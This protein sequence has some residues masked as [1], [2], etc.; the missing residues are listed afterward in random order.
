M[1][2]YLILLGVIFGIP[3]QSVMIKQEQRRVSGKSDL[4]FSGFTALF[5][6][7]LFL[8]IN[9]GAFRFSMEFLPYSIGF[10]V[11]YA[12]AF[13]CNVL[14]LSCGPMSLTLLLQSYSLLLPT[15]YGVLFLNEGV[16]ITFW[17]G[18]ALLALCLFLTYFDRSGMGE[19]IT[20]KWLILAL[21]AFL[22]NG[23]CSTVQKM[24][25]VALGGEYQNEFMILALAVIALGTLACGLWRERNVLPAFLRRGWYFGALCGLFNGGS[26]FGVMLLSHQ[27]PASLQYPLIS[28]G[29][30]LVTALFSVLLYRERLTL[31]QW[32]GFG[33]GIL[34]VVCLNL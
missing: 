22:G 3:L 31:R 24:Q 25:T 32:I 13:I 33:V 1:T 4:L 26:N 21:L 16:G 10:A 2:A 27:M 29:S 14:A 34:S 7:L 28:A 20:F 12:A 15:F 11:A 5:A 8:V 30:I 19:R 6:M 23:M 9:R 18:V 17:L